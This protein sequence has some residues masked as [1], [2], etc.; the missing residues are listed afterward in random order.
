MLIGVSSCS[1]S[2]K[3]PLFTPLKKKKK[4][5]PFFSFTIRHTEK[6]PKK[7]E[8]DGLGDLDDLD[9]DLDEDVGKLDDEEKE[10]IDLVENEKEA[11]DEAKEEAEEEPAFKIVAK[12][13][14][15][16]FFYVVKAGSWEMLKRV[17]KKKGINVTHPLTHDN[18]LMYALRVGRSDQAVLL[19]KNGIDLE[20]VNP[21]GKTALDIAKEQNNLRLMKILSERKK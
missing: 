21:D 14:K 13:K 17:I 6:E 8:L 4:E 5:G 12:K 7:N 2:K 20:Y 11:K 10:D 16:T 19:I 18:L 3:G 1:S 15:R 9:A